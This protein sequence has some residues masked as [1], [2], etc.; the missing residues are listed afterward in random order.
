MPN[1]IKL[2][3]HPMHPMLTDF[4]IAL[5]VTSLL[6]DLIRIW[7]ADIF[8]SQTAY[9]TLVVGMVSA[10]PA[11]VTGFLEFI[12]IPAN[13]PVLKKGMAHLSV[14]IVAS[15]LFFASLAVRSGTSPDDASKFWIAVAL[16]GIGALVLMI[17]GWLGG[18]LVFQYGVGT[19]LFSQVSETQRP[20][21]Q[22]GS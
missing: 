22:Q 11:I 15:G 7:R 21:Q 18:D 20:L 4:P 10:V 5:W 13:H 16:S 2:L 9:W 17:G 3:R 6:W 8:W 19:R 12:V 1:Q 14:M